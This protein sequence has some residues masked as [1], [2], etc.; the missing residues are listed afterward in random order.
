M[1]TVVLLKDIPSKGAS[2]EQLEKKGQ[3]KDVGFQ[4][5]LNEEEHILKENFDGL[6][7]SEV[8]FLQSHNNNTLSKAKVQALGVITLAGSGSLYLKVTPKVV[9][10][11]GML[12]T[13]RRFVTSFNTS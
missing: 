10:T 2:R 3:I 5:H 13:Q 12:L 7:S 4:R 1:L 8:E 9:S 6:N 11:H